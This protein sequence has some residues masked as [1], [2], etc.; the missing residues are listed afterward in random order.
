ML[1]FDERRLNILNAAR[2]EFASPRNA[3][4]ERDYYE[5]RLR[6]SWTRARTSAM[7]S[8][9]PDF[10]VEEF[11]NLPTTSKDALKAAPLDFTT[12]GLGESHKYYE[13]TGTSGRPT[14]TPRLAEDVIWNVVSVAEAWRGVIKPDDRVAILLPSD[15]VPVGDLVV[16]VCEYLAVTHIRAYPFTTGIADWDRVAEMWRSFRPTVVF[17][18]P[19]VA[20]HVTRAAKSRDELDEL[21]SSVRALM[22]LGEVSTAP[23]RDRLGQWW[24]A[25]AYDA[26][27]GS[28]ETGTLAATCAR[29]QLHLLPSAAYFELSDGTSIWPAKGPGVGR[30]VVTPLRLHARP[31][32]RMDT[33]DVVDLEV[34]CACGSSVP[35]VRVHGRAAEEISVRGVGLAVRDVETV[36]FG[37]AAVTAYM[38]EIDDSGEHVRLL[39]ERDVGADRD[40][41]PDLV[42]RVRQSSRENLGL[43]WDGV[44]FLNSLPAATKSG[45]SQKSWKRSNVRIVGG[46]R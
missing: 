29:G 20:M 22:L 32:L 3:V 5:P 23:F 15:V 39:L 28:T 1:I 34:G 17:V 44:V 13:T 24:G 19:G 42:E 40:E 41:E 33:G 7:Y 4:P 37:C 11:E 35:T 8:G 38:I 10:S 27:Y 45:A 14:P 46:G 36:V 43:D 26:S 2:A 21:R 9:L 25:K 18:A 6:W 16:G 31:L 30:L 12:V